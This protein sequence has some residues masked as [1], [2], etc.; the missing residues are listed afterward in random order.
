[1]WSSFFGALLLAGLNFLL[2]P[3]YGISGAALAVTATSFVLMVIIL[4]A[5]KKEFSLSLHPQH[6]FLSLASTLA[7]S[8]LATLLSGSHLLFILWSTLLFGLHLVFLFVTKVLKPQDFLSRVF[9]KKT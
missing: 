7:I 5:T 6:F 4:I 9:I 2:I 1:M 8:F 3:R